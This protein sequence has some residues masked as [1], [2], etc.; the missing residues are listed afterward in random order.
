MSLDVTAKALE[1][2]R[3]IIPN[4]IRIGILMSL[5][6]VHPAQLKEAQTT[7]NSMGATVVPVIARNPQEFDKAFAAVEREKCDAM[8]VLADG[9]YLPIVQYANKAKVPT[10]YQVSEFVRAGGLIGFGPDFAGLFKRGAYYVDRI[11]KGTKP[12]DL[13]VER[14]TKFELLINLK[15]AKSLGLEIPPTLLARADE[16]IE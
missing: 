11:L 10:L 7:A 6:P 8:I 13:P 2:L 5:N 15:T 4:L 9:L 16:V 3:E 1:I 14:P 12:S